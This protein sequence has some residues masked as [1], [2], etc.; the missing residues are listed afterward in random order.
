LQYET[1]G[2]YDLRLKESVDDHRRGEVVRF[3]KENIGSIKDV[4]SW[5]VRIHHIRW[6]LAG[7]MGLFV[8]LMAF[9]WLDRQ[10]RIEWM[11]NTW[12]YTKLLVPLLF[13]GVFLVG[14]L[15]ALV[16]EEQVARWVGDNGFTS[17]LIAS[18]IGCAFYFATLTEIPIL[19]T[20]I[21]NGMAHGPALALLLA[22]PALSIPSILVIRSVMGTG[23]T[24]VFIVLVILMA[25]VAGLIFGELFPGSPA[26]DIPLGSGTLGHE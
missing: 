9:T 22:G 26:I 3:E 21:D 1:T 5:V 14:F 7:A 13:G 19:Q 25:A 8:A 17:N 4:D 6:Y 18:V 10:D 11:Q 20:L 2:D 24:I 16:P 12:F 23:K 15:G